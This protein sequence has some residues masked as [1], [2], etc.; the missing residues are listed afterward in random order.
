MVKKYK[1]NVLRYIIDTENILLF[2]KK[3]IKL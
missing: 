3:L 2:T 1:N